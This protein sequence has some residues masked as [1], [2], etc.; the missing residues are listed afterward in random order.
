MAPRMYRVHARLLGVCATGPQRFISVPPG[1]ILVSQLDSKDN[2]RMYLTVKWKDR[3]LLVFPQDL[4]ER[5]VLCNV[6]LE[7]AA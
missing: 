1:E 3:N 4:S 5:A 7:T 2:D 6:P